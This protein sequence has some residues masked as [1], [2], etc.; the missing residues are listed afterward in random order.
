[1]AVV[2]LGR[3]NKPALYDLGKGCCKNRALETY[4]QSSGC[5]SGE[6]HAAKQDAELARETLTRPPAP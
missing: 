4:T 1:M 5:N 3:V 2:E 6:R